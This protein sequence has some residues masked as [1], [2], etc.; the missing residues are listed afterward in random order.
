MSDDFNIKDLRDIEITDELDDYL[1]NYIGVLPK[2]LLLFITDYSQYENNL[3]QHGKYEETM[4][5]YYRIRVERK[6]SE[7]KKLYDEKQ[8]QEFLQAN[9]KIKQILINSKKK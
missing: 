3:Q 4:K 6:K 7:D 9:P 1:T 2:Y 8:L 5:E